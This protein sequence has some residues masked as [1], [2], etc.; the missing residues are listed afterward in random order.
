MW[1][2]RQNRK[3]APNLAAGLFGATINSKIGSITRIIK[4][5]YR[6]SVIA[7]TRRNIRALH[8]ERLPDHLRKDL[9]FDDGRVTRRRDPMRD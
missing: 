3:G 6:V 9:G 7:S 5:F 1:L 4:S 8:P 2:K